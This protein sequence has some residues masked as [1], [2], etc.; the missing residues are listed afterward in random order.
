MAGQAVASG[1]QG[2]VEAYKIKLGQAQEEQKIK[3][4]GY[5]SAA[6]MP[7]KIAALNL[8]AQGAAERNRHNLVTEGQNDM[9]GAADALAGGIQAG[10]VSPESIPKRGPVYAKVINA[11]TKRNAAAGNTAPL[12]LATPTGQVKQALFASG[13]QPQ[14]IKASAQ[15]LIP[16]LDQYQ[17]AMEAAKLSDYPLVNKVKQAAS[18]QVGSDRYT[19]LSK[20][21]AAIKKEINMMAARGGSDKNLEMAGEMLSNLESPAQQK[22]GLDT[23]RAMAGGRAEAYSGQNPL[24]AKSA[25]RYAHLSDE[26]LRAAAEAQ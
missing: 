6:L 12:D 13:N 17:S 26:E 18:Y 3:Q 11:L 4:S 10:T 19:S 16:L 9:G 22:Q 7:M 14:Q 20:A 21:A 25:S 5:N 24:E 1:L 2:L 15:A 8:N 23:I